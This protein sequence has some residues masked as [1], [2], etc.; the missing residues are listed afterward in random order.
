V[1]HCF[2]PRY[3]SVVNAGIY[4]QYI[5]VRFAH[6][7]CVLL[8]IANRNGLSLHL[9]SLKVWHQGNNDW[10]DG[11]SVAPPSDTAQ[12]FLIRHARRSTENAS[13][14]GLFLIRRVPVV[15]MPA[16]SPLVSDLGA[17]VP[18]YRYEV[19]GPLKA[20]Q[21]CFNV[22]PGFSLLS[23]ISRSSNNTESTA[24]LISQACM[25]GRSTLLGTPYI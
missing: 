4:S 3:R 20:I 10:P 23:L 8:V 9:R 16:M 1:R 12:S 25:I 13:V 6:T 18:Y 19:V 2:T 11:P 5:L 17:V 14:V 15:V 7:L 24:L 22:L 21:Q